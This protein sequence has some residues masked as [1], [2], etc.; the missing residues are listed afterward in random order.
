MLYLNSTGSVMK[1]PL[2]FLIIFSFFSSAVSADSATNTLHWKG[3]TPSILPSDSVIITGSNGVIPYA[4][5]A[6]LTI[7][8]NSGVFTS[9]NITLELHYRRCTNGDTSGNCE[10]GQTIDSETSEA[11]GDLINDASWVMNTIDTIVGTEDMNWPFSWTELKM[12]GLTMEK[13]K[14]ITA[15][16]GSV[17]FTTE[18][19]TPMG[20]LMAIG[21]YI[22]V[23]TVISSSK[24]I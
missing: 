16:S 6:G 14:P 11:V 2:L 24:S 18:N 4:D 19:L 22:E 8:D 5:S 1:F 3:I 13:S 7:A 20:K 10:A 15:T 9:D 12:N 17:T 23:H 21:Q